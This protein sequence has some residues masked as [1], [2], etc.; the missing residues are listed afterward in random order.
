M[1]NTTDFEVCPLCGGWGQL[2]VDNSKCSK[3]GGVG[4][5]LIKGDE[6]L[7]LKLPGYVDFG[8]RSRI[9]TR[10]KILGAV[11]MVIFFIVLVS[12]FLMIFKL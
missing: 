2:S 11:L 10:K 6:S 12:V 1:D 4:V 9:V 8:A 3:C 7:V 5:R